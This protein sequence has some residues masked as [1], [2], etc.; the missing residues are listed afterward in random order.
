MRDLGL[1]GLYV[2]PGGELFVVEPSFMKLKA[3][4]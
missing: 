2:F 1:F 3:K 4:A